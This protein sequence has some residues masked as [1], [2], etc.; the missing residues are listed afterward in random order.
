MQS[1]FWHRFTATAHSPIGLDPKT[2]GIRIIGPA[3]AGFAENDLLHE[4]PTGPTPEWIGEGLRRSMLNFLEGR[5]LAMDV[6]SW[7]DHPT[8]KPGVSSTWITR[9]LKAHHG[10]DD[11][12]VE[13]RCVWIGKPAVVD[14]RDGHV[15]LSLQGRQRALTVAL[16][17]RQATWLSDLLNEALSQRSRYASYPS[18]RD[19]RQAFPGRHA[20]LASFIRN[21]SWER[22]RAAGLLLV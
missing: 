3:F 20:E 9:A 12:N 22:I 19:A 11:A 15:R 1:A 2:H 7:F 13:R 5:G 10:I 18:W 4:D 14:L 21:P 17:S 8:P 6:R 16:P